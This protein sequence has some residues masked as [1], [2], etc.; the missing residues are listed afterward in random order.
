MKQKRLLA[1]FFIAFFLMTNPATASLWLPFAL[2]HEDAFNW[3]YD[4]DT[5]SYP[6]HVS[7]LGIVLPL[8]DRNF[9][10]LWI[11]T[12]RPHELRF[13][14]YMDCAQRLAVVHDETGTLYDIPLLDYLYGKPIPPDSV[15]D[16]LHLAVCR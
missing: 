15:L 10:N 5:I 14:V 9:Q 7:I 16:K 3:Y 13:R 6:R 11:R 1:L 12:D 8:R 2:G 4:Q